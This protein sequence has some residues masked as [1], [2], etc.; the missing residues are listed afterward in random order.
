MSTCGLS[1][2]FDR[3]SPTTGQ[4]AYALLSRPP[5]TRRSVRLACVKRAASVRPE[6]GSN[7]HRNFRFKFN[8]GLVK[9]FRKPRTSIHYSAVK[10][11]TDSIHQETA[12][13]PLW[14]T[15]GRLPVCTLIK[16]LPTELVYAAFSRLSNFPE[17]GEVDHFFRCWPDASALVDAVPH[18]PEDSVVVADKG[19][20]V[21]VGNG[22]LRVHENIL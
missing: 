12:R 7:P 17:R 4:I 6:P 20:A 21:S 18:H 2:P 19:Y 15:C 1:P 14:E 9:G 5:L 22:Y 3:L 8:L 11:R 13:F 10:V 16:E